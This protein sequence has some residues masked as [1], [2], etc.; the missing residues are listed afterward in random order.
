MPGFVLHF[1]PCLV[2]EEILRRFY[3]TASIVFS[4]ALERMLQKSTNET[5]N[6][7][8]AVLCSALAINVNLASLVDF[9]TVN[10]THF[11][12]NLHFWY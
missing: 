12:E 1:P 4:T 9:Y 3:L 11:D 10:I 2:R 5:I 7:F 6:V 8:Q